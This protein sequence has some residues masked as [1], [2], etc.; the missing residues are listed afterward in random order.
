[1]DYNFFHK[2]SAN[3]SVT[4]F[5][6]KSARHKQLAE[7]IHKPIIRNFEKNNLFWI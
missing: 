6:N 3:S 5:T 2:K 1:M 4:T 7:H